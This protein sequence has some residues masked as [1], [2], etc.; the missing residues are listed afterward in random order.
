MNK[1]ACDESFFEQDTP[2]SFYVAGFIAADGGLCR[3]KGSKNGGYTV[4]INLSQ[5]DENFLE[6]IRE[7]I[8]SEK[9]L[10]HFADKKHENRNEVR[11]VVYSKKMFDSLA[12]FGIVPQKSKILTLPDWLENHKLLNHYLRGYVDGDGSFFL[13]PRYDYPYWNFSLRGSESFISSFHRIM[14][15][16][17]GVISKVNVDFDGGINRIRY[18]GNKNVRKIRDF[19]YENATISL[20]RK[21]P[22]TVLFTR[23]ELE[24]GFIN[25]FDTNYIYSKKLGK[26]L[27][28]FSWKLPDLTSFTNAFTF[29]ENTIDHSDDINTVMNRVRRQI[30]RH[31]FLEETFLIYIRPVENNPPLLPGYVLYLFYRSRSSQHKISEKSILEPLEKASKLKAFL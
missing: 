8:K 28:E 3:K 10:Y 15:E 29:S 24:S 1:Y 26:I 6:Q 23:K 18:S 14:K 25:F 20:Y 31:S 22:K 9:P 17:V 11:L 16:R 2:E 12:R 7:I 13:D 27:E 4:Q 5:R 21:Y 19:L 30:N